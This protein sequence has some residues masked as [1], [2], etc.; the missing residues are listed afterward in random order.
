MSAHESIDNGRPAHDSKLPL[1]SISRMTYMNV[2]KTGMSMSGKTAIAIF[3]FLVSAIVVLVSGW[4]AFI[5]TNATKADLVA[6]DSSNKVHEI[7]IDKDSEPEAMPVVVKRNA[8]A[9]REIVK[10]KETVITVK[11]GFHEDR[12]ERLADRA[13][14]KVR[15]PKKSLD[16]WKK[17]KRKAMSNLEAKKPIRDGLED[18]L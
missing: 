5:G 3:G 1:G 7:Q 12:S 9:V 15:D 2:D 16:R 8:V 13:A 6:H 18:Y 10:I 11:N 4:F 14:D 17:V